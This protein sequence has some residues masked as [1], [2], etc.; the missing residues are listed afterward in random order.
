MSGVTG[1]HSSGLVA[2]LRRRAGWLLLGLV[3]VVALV[4]G[5]GQFGS[6]HESAAS[7]AAALDRELRCP[8]CVDLSVAQSDAI[9][10]L[11]IRVYVAHA[12]ARGDSDRAIIGY[13]ESRY[14][15]SVLMAPGTSGPGASLWYLAGG[16]GLLVVVAAGGF[17]VFRARQPVDELRPSAEDAALVARARSASPAGSELT[18]PRSTARGP[19]RER[20]PTG[21]GS[22]AANEAQ[23]P[24]WRE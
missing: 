20:M 23:E 14:G 19:E 9:T 11:A 21:P 6:G 1:S 3:L 24:A 8:S 5:S 17:L 15:A 18:G 22:G 16:F 10:A 13:L 7:R 12:V 2:T 4:A